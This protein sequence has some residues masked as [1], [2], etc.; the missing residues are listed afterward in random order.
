MIGRYPY[1][2]LVLTD[3]SVSRIHC[4]IFIHNDRYYVADLDAYSKAELDGIKVDNFKPRTIDELYDHEL[5]NGS[6]LTIGETTFIFHTAGQPAA[7]DKK[8]KDN[9]LG[10]K[11]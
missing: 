4:R 7:E 6:K 1:N 3:P 10:T 5:T 11:K 9:P 8:K 2:E